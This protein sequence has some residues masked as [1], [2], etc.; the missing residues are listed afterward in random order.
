VGVGEGIVVGS[1]VCEETEKEGE[2]SIFDV[3]ILDET[4][5]D[6]GQDQSLVGLT[7]I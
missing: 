7:E 3:L 2:E 5:D 6:L 4:G 1:L